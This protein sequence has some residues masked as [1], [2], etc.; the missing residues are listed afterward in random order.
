MTTNE[1]TSLCE[2]YLRNKEGL[3]FHPKIKLVSEDRYEL[4]TDADPKYEPALKKVMIAMANGAIA[5]AVASIDT[6]HVEEA[7]K[8]AYVKKWTENVKKNSL[9]FIQILLEYGQEKFLE[10]IFLE[11]A[12]Y[13]MAYTLEKI[14]P[15]LTA[16]G[17]IVFSA[18]HQNVYWDG[19]WHNEKNES[20]PLFDNTLNW[21]RILQ[22]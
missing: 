22:A 18:P 4:S 11:Q 7:D 10:H 15:Q 16:D 8:E 9:P 1:W 19:D 3:G 21:K 17:K 2:R 14:H 12:R 20:V 5:Y 13:E 6:G